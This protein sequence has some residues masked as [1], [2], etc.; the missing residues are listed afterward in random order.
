[1]SET[2]K[3]HYITLVL[4]LVITLPIWIYLTYKIMSLVNATDVMWLLYWLYVPS[5]ILTTI[6][7]KIADMD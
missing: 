4:S 5:L 7:G 2:N 1:M 6:F 3:Y